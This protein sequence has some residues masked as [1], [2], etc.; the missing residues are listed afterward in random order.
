[1]TFDEIL[2][3]VI[4][5]LKRQ[6]RVSYG[7]LRRRYDL[8]EAYLED[9]K[10]EIIKAQHL[11]IDEDGSVMVWAGGEGGQTPKP[12]SQPDRVTPTVQEEPTTRIESQPI[13]SHQPEAERRQL[14]VMFVDMVGSTS[15][16]GQL[17]PEDL[18]DVVRAYQST[19]TEVVQRYD[20][21]VAQLLGDGILVYFGY[22]QAH[23]DDAQRAVRAGLGMLEAMGTLNERLERDHRVK[24]AVRVGIHTGLV[25]VGEMG[26]EG[27]Q[28]QLALGETPNVA[29]RIQGLAE[30]DQ[31]V[32]SEATLQLVQGYFDCE[33]LGEQNLR[34]VA[35]S[36]NFY[37]VLRESGAQSRL[38]V[39]TT[40]G[41]TPLVGP[42]I[43]G[44]VTTG[45][46][47]ASPGGLRPG[48]TAQ[49]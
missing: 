49:W 28:E 34:G 18:R 33:E 44:G 15:L 14:T 9:L 37:R 38:D 3:Q 27:R 46:M 26:R 47:G 17:D 2:E 35:Q 23:E 29:A 12:A 6:G 16:S 25:V 21:H 42:R 5:L 24:L 43:G 8:D 31:V 11:A 30:P 22:P 13:E 32:I 10:D 36:I 1:M 4:T 19:C 39:A 40:R 48:R 41:L 20:G 45:P 7:A